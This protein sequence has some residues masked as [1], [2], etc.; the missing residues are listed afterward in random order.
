MEEG[1]IPGNSNNHNT[2][3]QSSQPARENLQHTI[4]APSAV[5]LVRTVEVDVLEYG[6]NVPCTTSQVLTSP[7]SSGSSNS[8]APHTSRAHAR[9]FGRKQAPFIGVRANVANRNLFQASIE[10]QSSSDGTIGQ[11]DLGVF[12]REEE[13]AEAFDACSVCIRC[14]SC[15]PLRLTDAGV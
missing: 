1:K 9:P 14:A 2:S 4:N 3:P 12:D 6:A 15:C 11:V 10:A 13:A 7:R 8:K 5:R